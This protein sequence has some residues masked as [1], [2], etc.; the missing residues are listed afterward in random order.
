MTQQEL[1]IIDK[2]LKGI[3]LRVMWA[4]IVCTVVSVTTV[5]SIYYELK[6]QLAIQKVEI[7]MLDTRMQHLENKMQ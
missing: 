4:L 1:N 2:Q 6:T 5:L 7:R 3:N